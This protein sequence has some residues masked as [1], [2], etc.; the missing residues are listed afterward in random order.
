MRPSRSLHSQG[1]RLRGPGPHTN[2][3]AGI[4]GTEP[5]ATP[6]WPGGK[7]AAA[8]DAHFVAVR[9]WP[10]ISR[11]LR[12][13]PRDDWCNDCRASGCHG[14]TVGRAATGKDDGCVRPRTGRTGGG[15]NPG[16]VIVAGAVLPDA[17]LLDLFGAPASC[18]RDETSYQPSASTTSITGWCAPIVCEGCWSPRRRTG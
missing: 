14:G 6:D 12:G 4:S 2:A 10:L 8:A 1:Q 7:T 18:V 16:G 15:R 11:D 13:R 17:D 5:W 9:T 3:A